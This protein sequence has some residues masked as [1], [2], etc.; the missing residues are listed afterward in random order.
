MQDILMTGKVDMLAVR[1]AFIIKF[2][3]GI[4]TW[5]IEIISTMN[6][7]A[8]RQGCRDHCGTRLLDAYTRMDMV[9]LQ[10]KDVQTKLRSMSQSMLGDSVWKQFTGLINQLGGL[11]EIASKGIFLVQFFRRQENGLALAIVS[12]FPQIVQ[13]LM[14]TDE[15]GGTWFAYAINQEYLRARSVGDTAKDKKYFEEVIGSGLYHY[16]QDEYHKA[17]SQL[18]GLPCNNVYKAI[19]EASPAWKGFVGTLFQDVSLMYY[20]GA[21]ARNPSSFSLTSLT[22]MR[23]TAQSFLWTIWRLFNR[24]ESINEKLRFIRDYYSLLEMKN[25]VV[26]GLIPYPAKESLEL[27]GMKIEFRN[28]SMKYPK[29]NKFALRNVSFTIPAGATVILVGENGSG[30]T[31][32][33]SLLSRLFNATSGEILIDDRPISDYQV[34]TLREAQAIMRQGYQHFPFSIKENI[35]I[36]NPTWKYGQD[37]PMVARKTE[38]KIMQAAQL[39]GAME[40][41]EDVVGKDEKRKKGLKTIDAMHFGNGKDPKPKDETEKEATDGEKGKITGWDTNVTPIGTWQGSWQLRGTKLSE[42]SE[43]VEKSLEL[44]GGQWQRLALARLFMRAEREQVRLVCTDEPSAALDPKAEYDI[45][46][47][48]RTSQGGKRTRIFITH[49]FGH[50]T[51]HADLILC[52]KKGRLVEC[53]THEELMKTGGEYNSLYNIQ[54]QAFQTA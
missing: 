1:K 23:E 22:V 39:G 32:T 47:N 42:I 33:V 43:E 18:K 17:Q 36:G 27:Q 12:I 25:E 5:F 24:D 53:G 15:L 2:S 37:D 9:T 21:V 51:K 7:Q 20:L 45:F 16:L 10:R 48:L 50:L 34:Q 11:A 19:W 6:Q 52:L 46:H 13:A 28:V 30:K 26:D 4:L 29:S 35:G 40:V 14:Y 44:S 31:T 41:I 49:R 38:E 3:L 54:A 8:L